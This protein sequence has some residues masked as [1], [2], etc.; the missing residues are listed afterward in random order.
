MWLSANPYTQIFNGN[1]SIQKFWS[2][3]LKPLYWIYK[4]SLL[5]TLEILLIQEVVGHFEIEFLIVKVIV[6]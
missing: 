6:I 4:F 1:E 5:V 3:I 2:T